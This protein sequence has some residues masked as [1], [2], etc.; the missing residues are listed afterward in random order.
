MVVRM[1][2]RWA[3]PTAARLEQLKAVET[4]G[5]M[6]QCWAALMVVDWAV[7]LDLLS[8]VWWA[9]WTAVQLDCLWADLMVGCSVVHLV[10]QMVDRLVVKSADC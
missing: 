10:D 4:A 8:V 6:V 9:G 3:T 1:A 5:Q 2:E 7:W